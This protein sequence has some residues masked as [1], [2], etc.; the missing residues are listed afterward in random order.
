[1][2]KQFNLERIRQSGIV[3]VIRASSGQLLV[4]VAE[5]LL[6]GGVD[7]MEVTFTVPQRTKCWSRSPSG[8]EMNSAGRRHRAGPGNS[9]NCACY[10]EPSSS[11]RPR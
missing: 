11:S 1:M 5:S 3:A 8:W 10:R 4:E 6:A 7:M 2:S 9:P